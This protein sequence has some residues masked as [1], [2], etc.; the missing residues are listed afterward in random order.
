LYPDVVHER[1]KRSR[2]LRHGRRSAMLWA[3]LATL[4]RTPL[5]NLSLQL[6]GKERRCVSPFV[7]IGNNEYDM[8]GFHIGTRAGFDDGVLSIY[9]TTRSTVRGLIGL[10]FRALFKR[11]DQ[12]AD[13][14]SLHA[15]EVRIES[16]KP[17]LLVATDGEIRMLETRSIT[18]SCRGRSTCI[19]PAAAGEDPRPSLGPALR[20]TDAALLGRC[21]SS[22]S[23]STPTSSSSRA[24]SRSARARSSSA[25]ARDYLDTLP[26]PQLIVPG[27]HD[28]PLYNV[29]ARFLEP[30]RRY[31]RSITD[32][33]SPPS[34]TTRSPWWA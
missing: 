13:F 1:E 12:A 10:A 19:V 23:R 15:R 7:F 16:R 24:T 5:L 22:S 28:I 18:G 3:V 14:S 17:R 9:M 8:E 26:K 2:R 6:D 32:D 34:S 29:S 33:L 4:R 21:A 30:A 27:N 20:A 25:A 31:R 11:L